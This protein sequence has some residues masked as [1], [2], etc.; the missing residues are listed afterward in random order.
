VQ[1]LP[2]GRSVAQVCQGSTDW[3]APVARVRAETPDNE[4]SWNVQVSLELSDGRVSKVIR[5]PP[6]SLCQRHLAASPRIVH[7]EVEVVATDRWR[8]GSRAGRA[9]DEQDHAQ[10][11]W[12]SAREG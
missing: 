10:L 4:N 11:R 2:R 5:L 8:S 7:R 9:Q 12:I 1:A 6:F 3:T